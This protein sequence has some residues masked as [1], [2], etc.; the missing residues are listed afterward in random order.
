MT[1]TTTQVNGC[2]TAINY[3]CGDEVSASAIVQISISTANGLVILTNSPP[4]PL[5]FVIPDFRTN[6]FIQVENLNNFA[7]IWQEAVNFGHG[8]AIVIEENNIV[9]LS[10][11]PR[12][13]LIRQPKVLAFTG[14]PTPPPPCTP[15]WDCYPGEPGYGL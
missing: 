14:D 1:A 6:E 11:F 8:V 9:S 4:P 10:V 7:A 5:E 3:K 12:R 15:G 2:I 13:C